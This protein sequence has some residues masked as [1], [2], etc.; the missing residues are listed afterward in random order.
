MDGVRIMELL[1]EWV[2]DCHLITFPHEI[3]DSVLEHL[4]KITTPRET[5]KSVLNIFN[6]EFVTAVDDLRIS[7]IA[8][9]LDQLNHQSQESTCIKV[10][11]ELQ[12]AYERLALTEKFSWVPQ[13]QPVGLPSGSDLIRQWVDSIA[14]VYDLQLRETLSHDLNL[15]KVSGCVEGAQINLNH[16]SMMIRMGFATTPKFGTLGRERLG[17]ILGMPVPISV[18]YLTEFANIAVGH[19]RRRYSGGE[20]GLPIKLEGA[21]LEKISP[22]FVGRLIH[23]G[24]AAG[25][26]W[27]ILEK[28]TPDNH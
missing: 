23:K 12:K 21:E 10:P 13:L 8:S 25:W 15:G 4:E 3:T 22:S 16:G 6:F 26:A 1:E 24:E 20:Q 18:P 2:G 17:T 11:P 19:T 7:R 9:L 5:S 14:Y 28:P 27:I